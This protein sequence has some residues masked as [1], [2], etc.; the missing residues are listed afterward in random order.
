M[1]P[2]SELISIA[3]PVHDPYYVLNPCFRRIHS[4]LP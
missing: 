1:H 2:R 3:C 4:C